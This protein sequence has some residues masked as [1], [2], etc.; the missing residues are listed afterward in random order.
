MG[1]Q[2]GEHPDSNG[3]PRK[4]IKAWRESEQALERPTEARNLSSSG[5]CVEEVLILDLDVVFV[6]FSA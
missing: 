1:S 5:A 3:A 2:L 4:S 6:E